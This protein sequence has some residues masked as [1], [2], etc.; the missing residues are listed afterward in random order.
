MRHVRMLGYE[1]GFIHLGGEGGGNPYSHKTKT[2]CSKLPI[3]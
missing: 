2:M 3:H 1:Q